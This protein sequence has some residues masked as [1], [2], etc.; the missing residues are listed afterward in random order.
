MEKIKKKTFHD[1]YEAAKARPTPAQQFIE[2]IAELTSKSEYTVRKWI[3]RQQVP[4]KL[5][6]NVIAKHFGCTADGLFP[7]LPRAI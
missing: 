1:F 6:Q 7:A 2:D 4:D 3:A 5:T